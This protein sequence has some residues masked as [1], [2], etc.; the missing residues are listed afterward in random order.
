GCCSEQDGRRL[1]RRRENSA[2]SAH[3]RGDVLDLLLAHVLEGDGEPVAHL[4]AYHPADQMPPG[5]ARP[6][7]RAAMLTPSPKMSL[8][9]MMM[10]LRL[11]PIRKSMRRSARTP[12]LRT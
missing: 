10:S 1:R 3:R 5:S 11:M 9:S 4:I 6:S 7:R 2:I 8:S 12:T